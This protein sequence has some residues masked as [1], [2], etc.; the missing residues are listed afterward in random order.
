MRISDWS[1]DVCSSDRWTGWTEAVFEVGQV[2]RGHR[3]RRSRQP[4]SGRLCAAGRRGDHDDLR[5][6][7]ARAAR[8]DRLHVQLRRARTGRRLPD[9]CGFPSPLSPRRPLLLSTRPLPSLP[10]PPLFSSSLFV[11]FSFL[12]A[13]LFSFLFSFFFFLFF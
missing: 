7:H 1:S 13:P 6:R 11:S 5:V 8:E 3:G 9:A 10:S 4:G 12:F 2:G